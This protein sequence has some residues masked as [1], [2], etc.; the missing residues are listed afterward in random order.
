[1]DQNGYP[2]AD[3]VNYHYWCWCRC[4]TYSSY[5]STEDPGDTEPPD[6]TW[7]ETGPHGVPCPT[8][9][10]GIVWHAK[11]NLYV[12]SNEKEWTVELT[13]KSADKYGL[14]SVTGYDN[15]DPPGKVPV[16]AGTD[17]KTVNGPPKKRIFTFKLKPQPQWEVAT[18][19]RTEAGQNGPVYL[20]LK[21]YSQCVHV[22]L[23]DDKLIL[24]DARFGVSLEDNFHI[25][26]IYVFPESVPINPEGEQILIAPP[27]SGAWMYE[28]V[29]HDPDGEPR[30]QGGIRWWTDGDG[31]TPDHLYAMT[32]TMA[33][34]A[35]TEYSMF[36]FDSVVH[37]YQ[38]YRF[39]VSP[40]SPIPTVSEWGMIAMTLLLLTTGTIVIG[41]QRR[42]AAA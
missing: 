37:D 2:G 28:P 15:G 13:G 30:P 9:E 33:G 19:V 16:A 17:I 3:S 12:S 21:S 10:G 8:D 23:Q 25:T 24:E 35:D 14:G 7:V 18:F 27:D 31:L 6:G 11:K 5:H 1:M 39:E 22:Q 34:F 40:S 32:M 4:N 38:C 26:E 41:R 29:Y 20:T 36:A 42:L